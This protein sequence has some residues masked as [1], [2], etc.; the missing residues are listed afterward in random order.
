MRNIA[1]FGKI[2]IGMKT[3]EQLELN[4]KKVIIRVDFNVPLN[5]KQQITDTTRILAAKP[6]IDAVLNAGEVVF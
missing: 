5:E 4:G 6:T 1:T 2:F 3:L